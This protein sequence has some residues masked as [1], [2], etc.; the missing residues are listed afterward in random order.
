[1]KA[2]DLLTYPTL[3]MGVGNV[4][5][6]PLAMAIGRRPVFLLS[7]LIMVVGGIWCAFSKSLDVCESEVVIEIIMESKAK[8]YREP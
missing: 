8:T 3:F 2:N 1:L 6:M 5:A 7:I 4:I